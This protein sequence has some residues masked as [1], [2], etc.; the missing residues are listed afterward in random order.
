MKFFVATDSSTVLKEA[1]RALGKG[2]VLHY[3]MEGR[4]PEMAWQ[5]ASIDLELLKKC[6]VLVG[7]GN[8]SFTV[9]AHQQ[10]L[11][12]PWVV[13][14]ASLACS[15][16]SHSQR[17]GVGDPFTHHSLRG[18]CMADANGSRKPTTGNNGREQVIVKYFT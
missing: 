1:E 10:G 16:A 8:S 6:D 11:Q 14:S 18:T 5:G 17:L 15:G 3:K 13:R 7:T 9:A 2:R 4:A 12:K